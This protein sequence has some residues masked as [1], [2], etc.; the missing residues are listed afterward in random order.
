MYLI[1]L[2]TKFQRLVSLSLAASHGADDAFETSPDLCIAPN[3][4]ARMITFSD[5]MTKFGETYSLKRDG[6]DDSSSSED[7]SD[8][9]P[10]D[11]RERED[12]EDLVDIFHPVTS[13]LY[14]LDSQD[15]DWLC[16][17]YKSNQD[18]ELGTFNATILAMVVRKQSSKWE[19]ISLGSVSDVIVLVHRFIASALVSV[20]DDAN[21]RNALAGQ[22]S[23]ELT[24]RYQNAMNS[25]KFFSKWR[26]AMYP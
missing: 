2:A 15:M 11:V 3:I 20:R 23:D 16:Q 12:P 25:T 6:G 14:P 26:K 18:F 4:M 19:D 21:I 8:I 9:S 7:D 13:V 1:G 17:V 22:L 5:E 24:R 10:L